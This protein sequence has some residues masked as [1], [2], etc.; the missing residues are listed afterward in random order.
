[1]VAN[2]RGPGGDQRAELATVVG[3]EGPGGFFEAGEV[4]GH[5]GEEVVGGFLCRADAVTVAAGFPGFVDEA[6]EGNGG[7]ARLVVQP[8]PM[9]G[10]QRDFAGDDAELGT[11][12]AA[13]FLPH[14]GRRH[15]T[16]RVEIDAFAGTIIEDQH[17]GIV[18]STLEGFGHVR[19]V[20]GGEAV[21]AEEGG[22]GLGH[23][24]NIPGFKS[25]VNTS[26]VKTFPSAGASVFNV[27]YHTPMFSWPSRLL[28]AALLSALASAQTTL[29]RAANGKPNLQGIWQAQS[30]AAGCRRGG[31]WWRAV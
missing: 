16:A 4:A 15:D 8:I 24:R 27:V 14:W 17:Q 30:R 11:A 29:P 23:D 10:E 13:R 3:E 28:T 19:D 2:I 6:A 7:S 18:G 31:V 12:P 25:D 22:A 21:E 9:A 1:V 26:R 20:A 5:G